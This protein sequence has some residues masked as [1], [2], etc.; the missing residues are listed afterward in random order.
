MAYVVYAD[1]LHARRLAPA[2]HLVAQEVL[3]HSEQALVGGDVVAQLDELGH[4]SRRKTGMTI[5]RTDFGVLGRS[6]HP[7]RGSFGTTC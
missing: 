2:L 1:A 6:R 7:H 5:V 3:G 4:L